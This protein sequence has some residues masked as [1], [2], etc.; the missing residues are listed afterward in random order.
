MSS[1]HQADPRQEHG[2]GGTYR[3]CD[4]P[5]GPAYKPCDSD[6]VC[7][8]EGQDLCKEHAVE[9]LASMDADERHAWY[10][11]GDF[12]T[13]DEDEVQELM[14]EAYKEIAAK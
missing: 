11:A 9:I 1:Y 10:T 7:K 3:Y 6:A 13:L 14:V 4:A 12:G 5:A 8:I 2:D